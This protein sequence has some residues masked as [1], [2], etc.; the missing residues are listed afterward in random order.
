MTKSIVIVLTIGVFVIGAI[1]TSTGSDA[2]TPIPVSA[3][4]PAPTVTPN[5]LLYIVQDPAGT[6]VS[7]QANV[8]AVVH[9]GILPINIGADVTIG[10]NVVITGA[11]GISNTLSTGGDLNVDGNATVA[12]TLNTDDLAVADSIVW[13]SIELPGAWARGA[14]PSCTH[15]TVITHALGITPT[16]ILLTPFSAVTTTAYIM[17]SNSLTFAIGLVNEEAEADLY[18]YAGK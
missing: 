8:E 14:A 7:R 5:S 18:W 15:G 1:L 10:E 12:G 13:Q 3:M 9:S 11:L 17:E 16:V 4:T 2:A 6:P